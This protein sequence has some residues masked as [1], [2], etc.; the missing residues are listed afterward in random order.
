MG[1]KETKEDGR[2]ETDGGEEQIDFSLFQPER[3]TLEIDGC[4][5]RDTERK[6]GNRVKGHEKELAVKVIQLNF[7]LPVSSLILLHSSQNCILEPI[8]IVHKNRYDA[9]TITLSQFGSKRCV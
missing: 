2:D 9:R 5:S 1:R 6:E 3:T 7:S 4:E 8:S